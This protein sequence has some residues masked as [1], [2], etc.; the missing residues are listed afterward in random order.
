MRESRRYLGYRKLRKGK[1][2]FGELNLW[3]HSRLLSGEAVI[4]EWF[5]CHH[6]H[7]Q[8]CWMAKRLSALT[9]APILRCK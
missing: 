2:V 9:E 4:L 1:V 8:K 7:Y 6:H 5:V 3:M